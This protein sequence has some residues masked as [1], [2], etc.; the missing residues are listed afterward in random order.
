MC[1]VCTERCGKW[2]THSVVS[3]ETRPTTATDLVSIYKKRKHTKKCFLKDEPSFRGNARATPPTLCWSPHISKAAPRACWVKG[4][5]LHK[6]LRLYELSQKRVQPSKERGA[7]CALQRLQQ[8]AVMG[9]QQELQEMTPRPEESEIIR[10]CER[11]TTNVITF[12]L[13]SL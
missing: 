5:W 7:A 12:K 9:A 8:N 11:E 1:C 13:S 3:A 6:G 10:R 4:P 2:K